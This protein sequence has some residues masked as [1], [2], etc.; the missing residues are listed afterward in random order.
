MDVYLVLIAL[1]EHPGHLDARE[2]A[3]LRHR[4]V[5]LLFLARRARARAYRVPAHNMVTEY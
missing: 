5:R 3:P 1:H 2:L 4:H